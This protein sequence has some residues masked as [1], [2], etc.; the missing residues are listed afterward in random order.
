MMSVSTSP[1]TTRITPITLAAPI[2]LAWKPVMY[3]SRARMRVASPG[4][5]WVR[6]KMRSK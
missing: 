2:W 6:T 4:P 3:M 5:P 1:T